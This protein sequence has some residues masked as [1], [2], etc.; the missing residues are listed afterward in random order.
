MKEK[1]N[2]TA[3]IPCGDSMEKMEA[4]IEIAEE[5]LGKVSGGAGDSYAPKTCPKCGGVMIAMVNRDG[6]IRDYNCS[7]CGNKAV[8]PADLTVGP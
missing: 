2:E 5:Q 4:K 8:N 1:K 3:F 6:K 7:S